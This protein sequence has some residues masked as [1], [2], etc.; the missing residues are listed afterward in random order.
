MMNKNDETNKNITFTLFIFGLF[1]TKFNLRSSSEEKVFG[2][3][4]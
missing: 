1:S 4:K 3:K 2:E